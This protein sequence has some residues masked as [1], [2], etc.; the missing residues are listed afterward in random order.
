M[1]TEGE[2]FLIACA[3]GR[4]RIT[5]PILSVRTIK[6]RRMFESNRRKLRIV[7]F[8]IRGM[9]A[10]CNGRPRLVL[11]LFHGNRPPVTLGG[12][13]CIERWQRGRAIWWIDGVIVVGL[14]FGAWLL[15]VLWQLH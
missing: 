9:S 1:R 2:S 15:Y 10:N 4:V 8:N 3:I 7:S 5:S 14:L 12:S 11:A 13:V 6:M